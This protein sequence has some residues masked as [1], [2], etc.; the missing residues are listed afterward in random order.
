MNEEIREKNI[1]KIN[2]YIKNK[3]KSQ[4]IEDSIYRWTEDYI[5]SNMTGDFMFEQ[6]YNDKL[7]CI[8]KNFDEKFNSYFLNAIKENKINIDAFAFLKPEE[9]FPE[10]FES[11]IKKKSL[12]KAIRD[13]KA[14]SNA[15]K[16]PKCKKRKST[17]D[18]KQVRSGD[19]PMTTFVTCVECGHVQTFG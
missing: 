12:E 1:N 16:C 19:E 2:N 6:F 10:K 9:I 15:F 18:Q 5:E 17:I 3:K 14:T 7:D 8:I 4:K 13:N 11:I